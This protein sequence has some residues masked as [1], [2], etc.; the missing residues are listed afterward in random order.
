MN[1]YSA[2]GLTIRSAFDLPEL[3]AVDGEPESVDA[4]FRRDDVDPV[5][6]SVEGQGGRRIQ[7]EPGTCRFSYEGIGSFVVE[8]GERVRFDPDTPDVAERKVVRRLFENEMIGVL[9]HQRG[10]LVLHASAVRVDGEAVVFLG[11]RGAGK[12]TTAAAFQVTGHTMLED[13][14]VGIRFDDGTPT[15]VPGVPQLRL[16]PDAAEALGVEG[17]PQP[18]SGDSRQKLHRRLDERPDP[19]PLAKCYFL[20]EG[21]ELRLEEFPPREGLFGLIS[22]TYTRGMLSDTEKTPDNF[23]QCSRVVETTPF[24]EL[25]RTQD[26]EQLPSIVDMVAA[27]LRSSDVVE[28]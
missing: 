3:P 24:R 18:T 21:D 25:Y 1:V 5:P 13:D 20:R 28:I 23:E 8:A 26:H 6:E 19:A 14:V 22:Q 11:P 7:A 27:D 12:S 17:D 9:L 4:V 15:V 16:L 2:Y 10:H